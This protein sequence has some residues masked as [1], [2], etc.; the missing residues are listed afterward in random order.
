MEWKSDYSLGIQEID[1]QHR[2]LLRS[3]STIK[4]AIQLEQGWSSTHCSIM[5]L[6]EL[7]LMHFTLE[8]SLMRLFGYP[9]TE[10]HRSTHKHFL[11]TLDDILNM[12]IRKSAD[13]KMLAL[14]QDWL[15]EHILG[16]DK[17]YARHIL[18][19]AAIVRTS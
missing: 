3:F 19:G 6:K 13:S 12:S 18:S 4:E 5:E 14:L 17:D 8:E 7:A 16:T 1:D 11:V 15:T 10:E 9:E 2:M